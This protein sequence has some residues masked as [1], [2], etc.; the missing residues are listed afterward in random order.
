MDKG[1]HLIR[2]EIEE[3]CRAHSTVPSKDCEA[4]ETYTQANVPMAVMI[5]DPIVGGF[6]GFMVGALGARRI[7][8]VGC[9]T[10]YTALAMAERLPEDG[11]LITLDI[12]EETDRIAKRFW[13]KSPHGKKI[14]SMIGPAGDTLKQLKGPFDLVFVD[15]DKVGYVNYVKQALELLAPNGVL[16]A[17]NC[18]YQGHVLESS[19]TETGAQAIKEFNAFVAK[20]ERLEK[21]LLSVKDGLMLIRKKNQK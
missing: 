2:S 6:L 8:E 1:H 21:T 18:L 17:D 4:I 3:Y 10:G 16:I 15:A 11:E 12:S 9:F 20:N 13:A 19:P 14:R 7:L 5:S